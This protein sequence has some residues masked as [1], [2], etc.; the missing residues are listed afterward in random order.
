VRLGR[1]DRF[2]AI[3]NSRGVLVR[4]L[5]RDGSSIQFDTG[6]GFDILL[7]ASYRSMIVMALKGVL[8]HTTLLELVTKV[9]RTGDIVIDG[10]SNVGFFALLAAARLNGSGCVFAFEPDPKTFALLQQNIRRNRFESTIRAEQVALTDREGTLDFAVNSEEPMLSSLVPAMTDPVGS[11]SVHAAR[12]DA[13]LAASGLER[14]DVI[15]LDLEG[16]EPMALEGARAALRTT[17][18]LIFEANKPQLEQL[19]I[20]PLALVERTA[21]AGEFDTI[22][23]IDERSEKVCH[24]E[25]RFFEEALNDYKFINVVCTRYGCMES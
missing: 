2:S 15:K 17:R 23:F 21:R 3:R 12:L 24:W 4:M 9:I 10:G 7:P 16:A 5:A 20:D 13:F 11:I 19:G 25:P 8:F 6:F 18:M 1:F 14:A 22:Y